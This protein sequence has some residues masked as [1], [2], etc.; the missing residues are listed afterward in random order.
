MVN[1]RGDRSMFLRGLVSI[2]RL[3]SFLPSYFS[4]SLSEKYI[5]NNTR[6][7][8]RI[9]TYST[10][11]NLISSYK[12]W[13]LL[14]DLLWSLPPCHRSSYAS[15]SICQSRC[16]KK[17]VSAHSKYSPHSPSIWP[18]SLCSRA[19]SSLRCSLLEILDILVN[20]TQT[21]P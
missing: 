20:A 16:E 9:E 1:S 5:I 8:H 6:H 3:G 18:L 19:A 7:T 4:S 13:K 14:T 2:F 10:S 21:V 15:R 12:S 11:S 17:G